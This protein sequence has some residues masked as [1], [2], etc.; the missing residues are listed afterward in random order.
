MNDSIS[1]HMYCVSS[2]SCPPEC[3]RHCEGGGSLINCSYCS[4]LNERI[5]G[6]VYYTDA[7]GNPFPLD[8]AS[9]YAST[10][11]WRP[12]AST[13]VSGRFTITGICVNGTQLVAQRKGFTQ[14]SEDTTYS[15]QYFMMNIASKLFVLHLLCSSLQYKALLFRDTNC[16]KYINIYI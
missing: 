8:G 15:G 10:Q 3:S 4:C 9:I 7:G 14:G 16:Y 5:S 12:L 13:N 6:V 1:I 2:I 11:L